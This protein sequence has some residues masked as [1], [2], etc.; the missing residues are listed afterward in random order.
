MDWKLIETQRGVYDWAAWDFWV[1]GVAAKRLRILPILYNTPP[2]YGPSRDVGSAPP[3]NMAAFGRFVRAAVARYGPNGDFWRENP[4]VPKVPIV[5]W[6]VWNEPSLR[7]YWP[8]RPNARQ[9]VRML[10]VAYK[11]IKREDRRAEV[12][13]AGIPDSRQAGAI[14]FRP[15]VTALY[16]AGGARWFDTLGVNLYAPSGKGVIKLL[17]VARKLMNSRRGKPSDRKGKMWLTE[18]GWGTAG[19][20]HRFNLGAKRQAKEIRKLFKGAY[21]QR[22]K[23]KLRGIFYFSWQ[24]NEPYPPNFADQW[25]LHT[26]LFSLNGKPKPG[27]RAFRSVAPRLK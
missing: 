9:Y 12:V 17:R 14:P 22:R 13:T 3:K 20:R 27:Y 5:S 4:Q 19:P 15:Y 7:Q 8:P 16:R 26:G 24:D 21:K 10:K 6:Q 2:F 25:G 18:V 1:A 11:S 23:L